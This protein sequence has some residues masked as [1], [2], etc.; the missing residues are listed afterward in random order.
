MHGIDAFFQ[1]CEEK[2]YK[3]Q[4]RV[5]ASRY[6]GKTTCTECEG[7]RLRKEARYVKVGARDITELTSMPIVECL[8]FFEG[9]ELNDAQQRIASRLLKEITKGEDVDLTFGNDD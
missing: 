8:R 6:R 2:S 3:I 7:T 4:Y 5:L 9:L 1:Y